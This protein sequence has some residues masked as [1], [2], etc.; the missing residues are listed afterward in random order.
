MTTDYKYVRH[1]KSPPEITLNITKYFSKTKSSIYSTQCAT[2]LIKTSK[3]VEKFSCVG[4]SFSA[5]FESFLKVAGK[6]YSL[7][8]NVKLTD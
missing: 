6:T 8:K 1:G 2:I 4:T 7:Q 5:I 3:Y